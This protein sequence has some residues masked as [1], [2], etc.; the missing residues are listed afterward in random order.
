MSTHKDNNTENVTHLPGVSQQDVEARAR[1]IVEQKLAHKRA[2]EMLAE[3]RDNTAERIGRGLARSFK[4]AS[5]WVNE[6]TDEVAENRAER[7]ARLR[8]EE[9][10]REE[11][12]Q[13]HLDEARR[14]LEAEQADEDEV[15]AS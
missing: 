4:K 5:N 12:I 3:E 1:E 15:E 14:Q 2:K 13:A 10:A 6:K 11:L 9:I 7:K 8:A